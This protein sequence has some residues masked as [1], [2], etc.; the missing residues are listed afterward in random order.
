MATKTSS[1]ALRDEQEEEHIAA[2]SPDSFPCLNSALSLC[3]LYAPTFRFL[4]LF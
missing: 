2:A 3:T 4:V 1:A